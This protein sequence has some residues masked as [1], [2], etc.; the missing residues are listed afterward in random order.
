MAGETTS[1]AASAARTFVDVPVGMFAVSFNLTYSTTQNELND[2]MQAGYIG[3]NV[4]VH[5]V[6]WYPTDMDT[7]GS[8]AV[9]HKV[10]VNSVDAVSSLTGAQSGTASFT[11]VNP[12]FAATTPGTDK[13]LVTV[14]TTTAAATAAAGTAVLVLFCQHI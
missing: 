7:N 9:V 2:V 4:R 13:Q 8:P 10:T 6:G 12:T 5:A 1:V 3:P 14:T 11:P